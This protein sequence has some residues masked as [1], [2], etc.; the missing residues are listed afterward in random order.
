MLVNLRYGRGELSVDIPSAHV[1]VLAPTF[2]PGLADEAA[3]FR[4]AVRRPVAARPL[5]DCVG[6]AE[7]LAVAIPDITRPLPS[8]RLLPL[9]FEELA[10]VS[11]GR[12]TI[13]NGTGSHRVNTDEELRSMVGDATAGRFRIVNHSAHDPAGLAL[14]GRSPDGHPVYLNRFWVEADRLSLIHI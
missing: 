8:H 4:H 9:L 6:A 11:A 10:H 14:A 3:A 12:V 13:V 5:R 1:T 2:V 7:S